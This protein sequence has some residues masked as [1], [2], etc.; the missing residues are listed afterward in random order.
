[1]ATLEAFIDEL[2]TVVSGVSG[3]RSVPNDPPNQIHSTPTVVIYSTIGRAKQAPPDVVTTWDD[4]TLAVLVPLTDLPRRNAQMLQFRDS[5]PQAI[6]T[7]LKDG[8]LTTMQDMREIEHT[9]G[10]VTWGGKEM[11]GYLFT[12]KSVKQQNVI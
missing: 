2:I 6:Y 10:A 3:I 9:Y 7:A 12:I 5:V 11:F 8:T 1:M 4:V